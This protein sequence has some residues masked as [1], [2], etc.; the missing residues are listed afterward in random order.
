MSPRVEEGRGGLGLT[1]HFAMAKNEA[2]NEEG[3][4]PFLPP[5]P[6]LSFVRRQ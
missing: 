4:G 5:D 2:K 3:E 6:S 1:M